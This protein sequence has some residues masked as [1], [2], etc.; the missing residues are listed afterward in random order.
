MDRL[1]GGK[2]CGIILDF[3]MHFLAGEGD[4]CGFSLKN[5]LRGGV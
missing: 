5:G 3:L 2:K 4:F 1:F